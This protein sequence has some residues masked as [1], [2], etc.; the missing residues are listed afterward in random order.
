VLGTAVHDI[1]YA[2]DVVEW[3]ILME[4]ITHGIDENGAGLFPMKG[5]IEH[6]RLGREFEAVGVLRGTHCPQARGHAFGVTMF[7]AGADL[8]AAGDGI[9]CC[10][11]PFNGRILGHPGTSLTKCYHVDSDVQA[12]N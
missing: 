8:G 3:E 1:E 2:L 11:G 10:F 12:E 4:H 7:A 5:D 9:P 6:V